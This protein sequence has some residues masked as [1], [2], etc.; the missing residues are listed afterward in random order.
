MLCGQ[1]QK[2]VSQVRSTK[3]F[4]SVKCRVA[5]NRQRAAG[6]QAPCVQIGDLITLYQGDALQIAPLLK[7]PT[8]ALIADPPYGAA[9]DFTKK[10]RSKT[11]LQPC[12]HQARWSSTMIGD[13]QPFDPTPWLRY[14]QVILWGANHY[15]SRLPDSPAWL[16]WYKR[17]G[18]TPDDFADCEHAWT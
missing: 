4:C 15:A 17:C 6:L 14:P 7:Q 2:E 3:Q 10:R 1:C 9:F 16:T 8:H 5:W 13:D 11:S 18:K 12:S